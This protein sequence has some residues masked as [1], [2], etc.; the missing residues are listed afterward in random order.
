MKRQAKTKS[1]KFSG[2]LVDWYWFW[3][4]FNAPNKEVS[5]YLCSK[6]WRTRENLS[7]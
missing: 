7:I 4:D 2:L 1:E 5:S 3:F 6:Q